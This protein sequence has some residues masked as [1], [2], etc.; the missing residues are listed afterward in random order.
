[1]DMIYRYLN[2]GDLYFGF[3]RVRCGDCGH[4]Y[5]LPYHAQSVWDLRKYIY[6]GGM[7]VSFTRP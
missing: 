1:M 7:E 3:A 6:S 5:L 2:C 4:E